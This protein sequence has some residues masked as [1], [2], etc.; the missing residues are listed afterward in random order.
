MLGLGV[1]V[2]VGGARRGRGGPAGTPTWNSE[3]VAGGGGQDQTQDNPEGKF[4]Q[5]KGFQ[6]KL[7]SYYRRFTV[8][9]Y[10]NRDGGRFR[11][12]AKQ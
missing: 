10:S 2:G 5:R 4:K 12:V 3:S 8:T 9:L 1:G 7:L 6:Q 11:S